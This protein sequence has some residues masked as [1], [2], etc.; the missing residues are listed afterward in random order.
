MRLRN[1]VPVAM[2]CV[3]FATL[4]YAAPRI[5]YDVDYNKPERQFHV[6]APVWGTPTLQF[7]LFENGTNKYVSTGSV[8]YK[9]ATGASNNAMNSITGSVA[10]NVATV[11]ITNSFFTN[12]MERAAAVLLIVEA[13]ATNVFARGEQTLVNNEEIR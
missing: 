1:I 12:A 2:L 6:V 11:V 7:T 10:S 3:A 13:S 8:I 4:L 5:M 9:Y